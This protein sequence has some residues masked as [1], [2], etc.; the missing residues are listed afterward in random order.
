MPNRTGNGQD[1][2][3]PLYIDYKFSS[4]QIPSGSPTSKED[5]TS[6]PINIKPHSVS[7]GEGIDMDKMYREAEAVSSRIS[8]AVRVINFCLDKLES[9]RGK[10]LAGQ[11]FDGDANILDIQASLPELFCLRSISDSFGKV[12]LDIHHSLFNLN[13]KPPAET[14][15]N[16]MKYVLSQLK[17]HPR[18]QF[19]DSLSLTQ[20]LVRAELDPKPSYTKQIAEALADESIPRHDDISTHSS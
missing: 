14:Q 9:A 15:I 7:S 13:G 1:V 4:S 6:P 12:V 2:K 18:M 3:D 16:A 8:I 17:D 19:K 20:W 11:A 5:F 10:F